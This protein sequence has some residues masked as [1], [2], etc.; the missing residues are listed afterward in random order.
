MKKSKFLIIVFTCISAFN[1]F[2]S[3][4]DFIKVENAPYFVGEPG[5]FNEFLIFYGGNKIEIAIETLFYASSKRNRS[6]GRPSYISSND[7]YAK[8]LEKISLDN[9]NKD[10]KITAGGMGERIEIF[11]GHYYNI[12]YLYNRSSLFVENKNNE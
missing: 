10:I 8:I 6:S 7:I 9:P 5:N 1:A 3:N 12:R 2:C 11:R 4:V